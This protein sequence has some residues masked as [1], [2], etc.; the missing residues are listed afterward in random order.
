[1]VSFTREVVSSGEVRFYAPDTIVLNVTD[2]TGLPKDANKL[3]GATITGPK[4]ADGTTIRA[5]RYGKSN[6]GSL[7]EAAFVSLSKS[8]TSGDGPNEY[9]KYTIMM[10]AAGGRRKMS[11]S[12]RNKKSKKAMRKY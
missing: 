6:Y 8:M 2:M 5:V 7:F 3:I 10:P 11:R 1:M 4:I 9:D 12:S